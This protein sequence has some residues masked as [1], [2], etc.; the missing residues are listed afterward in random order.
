MTEAIYQERIKATNDLIANNSEI[1]K[2]LADNKS[3]WTE[4]KDYSVIQLVS[5]IQPRWNQQNSLSQK[6]TVKLVLLMLEYRLRGL[7]ME[8]FTSGAGAPGNCCIS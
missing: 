6:D 2:L 7:D 1:Q 8:Y 3:F 4:I 5:E